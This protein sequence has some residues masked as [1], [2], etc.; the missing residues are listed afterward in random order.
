MRDK[1]TILDDLE[2]KWNPIS[3]DDENEFTFFERDEF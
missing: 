1:M 2:W 3:D